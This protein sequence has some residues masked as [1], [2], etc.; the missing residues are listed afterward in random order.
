MVDEDKLII[1][2]EAK[3][4]ASQIINEAIKL[5]PA[6]P[7]TGNV[8]V[9]MDTAVILKK[10]DTIEKNLYVVFCIVEKILAE[11]GP[12]PEEFREMART[13]D[14]KVIKQRMKK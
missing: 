2:D 12:S 10:L 9:N 13:I 14:K 11:V 1:P 4:M 7:P 5:I 8:A 6:A 3:A